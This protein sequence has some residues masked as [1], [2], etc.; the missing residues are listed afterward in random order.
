MLRRRVCADVEADLLAGADTR[1]RTE[2]LDP[3]AAVL[4]GLVHAR[5]GQHPLPGAWP[6]VLLRDEVLRFGRDTPPGHDQ[7]G[8]GRPLQVLPTIRFVHER[9]RNCGHDP[10][11]V[12]GFEP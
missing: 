8:T 4:R 9:P 11:L 12:P 7:A 3:R 5:L 10:S 6:F 2:P 1:P